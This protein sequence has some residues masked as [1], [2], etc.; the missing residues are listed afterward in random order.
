MYILIHVKLDVNS[1]LLP[2]SS[3]V[4]VKLGGVWLR[5]IPCIFKL[6]LNLIPF[7]KH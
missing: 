2:Y 5:P 4:S 6:L 3:Y 7:F 1:T